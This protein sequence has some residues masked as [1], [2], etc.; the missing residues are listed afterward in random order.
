MNTLTLSRVSSGVIAALVAVAVMVGASV[1]IARANTSPTFTQAVKNNSNAT[2]TSAPIGTELRNVVSLASTTSSTTPTGTV[3][4][5]RYENTSCSGTATTQSSVSLVN[6]IATSSSV[7]IGSNGLSY[8]VHYNGD[9]NN[10]AADSS[11]QTVNATAASVSVAASVSTSTVYA[12]S[13]VFSTATLT[14]ETANATGTVT[15]TV[16]NNNLCTSGARSAGTKT[17]S[18]GNAPNSDTLAFNSAGTFY[19]QAVYSGDQF[20]SAATSPC[21]GAVLTVLA[22]STPN[23]PATS[24]PGTIS[25]TVFHDL[26]KNKVKDSNESGLSGWKVWLHLGSKKDGYNNPI[27]AT[28]TTDSNG[29]YSFANLAV[30]NYFVEQEEP[31]GWDQKTSDRKV[32]LSSSNTG[33][34][35]DFA[36]IQINDDNSGKDGKDKDKNGKRWGWWKKFWKHWDKHR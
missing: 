19:W 9:S 26:N 35:V 13:S 17:V 3:N 1:L 23:P 12:G 32:V 30:G 8:S 25:G 11:C 36:N 31:S 6:G 33:A 24:T 28:A 14:N 7:T 2:V 15:Y 5:N 20:N 10:T 21:Q 18:S 16:Y 34:T 22:T 29:R 27:I 4:F